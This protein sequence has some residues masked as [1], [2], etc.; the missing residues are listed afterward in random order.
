MLNASQGFRSTVRRLI[1]GSQSREKCLAEID[2]TGIKYPDLIY[3]QSPESISAVDEWVAGIS[4]AP[5]IYKRRVGFIQDA[6]LMSQAGWSRLL[7]ILESSNT[8]DI[9]LSTK[10]LPPYTILSRMSVSY[11]KGDMES[12]WTKILEN[13]R[14]NLIGNKSP[15]DWEE[16]FEV[17]RLHGFGLPGCLELAK[18]FRICRRG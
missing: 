15:A 10:S 1:I 5:L 18:N 13:C 12:E 4:C 11:S 14:A 7:D 9:W 17:V 8:S 6:H 3:L 16:W 2:D